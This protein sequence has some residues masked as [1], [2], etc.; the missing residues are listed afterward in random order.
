VPVGE[1]VRSTVRLVGNRHNERRHIRHG[2][3]QAQESAALSSSAAQQIACI[4]KKGKKV[5]G[6]EKEDE[7]MIKMNNANK[8]EIPIKK[9]TSV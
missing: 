5:G 9:K 2:T 7:G 4:P 1:A 8:K 6:G 3:Q